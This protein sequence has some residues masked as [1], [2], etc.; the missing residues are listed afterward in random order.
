VKVRTI[1]LFLDRGLDAGAVRWAGQVLARGAKRLQE[2]GFEVQGRRIALAHWDRGLGRLSPPAR[3][4][5]FRAL[6]GACREAG[7]DF[8]AVGLAR[9][10]EH[11]EHLGELLAGD[12]LFNGGADAAAHPDGALDLPA[13]RAAARTVKALAAARPGG[14]CTF[15]FACG[16]RIR[17]HT[18]FFPVA[19]HNGTEGLALAFENSDL[20]GKAFTG[21]PS[22][23][24]ARARLHRELTAALGSAA[25]AATR[26]AADEDLKFLGADTSIAPSLEP[27]DSLA[28]AFSALG[29]RFGDRGTLAICAAITEVL[30]AVPLTRCGYCGLML[31]V[32]EDHGLAQGA[33]RGEFGLDTLMVGSSVCGVGVDTVPVPGDVAEARLEALLHDV[34]AL[35]TRLAKPLSVRVLPAPGKGPGEMTKF[36]S[37]YLCNTRVFEL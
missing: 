11:I 6:G 35:A 9:L 16:F 8:C 21:A 31:S 26:F 18:P 28:H 27:C 19:Y 23:Q 10:P 32:M 13:A 24:E 2:E 4:E 22:L 25:D 34:G 33:A 29:V 1:T 17:P 14:E 37:E 15:Q 12:A 5:C 7:V 20:V 3:A 30:N 36:V